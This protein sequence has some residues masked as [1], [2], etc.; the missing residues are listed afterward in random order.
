MLRVLPEN[1]LRYVRHELFPNNEWKWLIRSR[2]L[3]QHRQ[4]HLLVKKSDHYSNQISLIL[5]VSSAL[6]RENDQNIHGKFVKHVITQPFNVFF[7][8]P[9]I[10][11]RLERPE[12]CIINYF[13][14]AH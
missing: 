5:A 14:S 13:R 9:G 12:Q 10:S 8:L 7:P 2:V 4:R 11:S 6:R 1:L 3:N